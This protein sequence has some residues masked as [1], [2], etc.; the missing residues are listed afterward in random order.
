MNYQEFILNKSQIGRNYGFEPK[1]IPGMLFDF[2]RHLVEWSQR[3]GRAAIFADCGMGK[4]PM[5]LTWAYNVAEK[6]GKPVLL[7]T[8]LAVGKQMQHEGQK[9]QI[10]C[11]RS[12]NGNW[13]KD[14]RI[15]ITNYERLH[16]FNPH[17]FGG[18]VC[19]ESS[20]LK[21]YDGKTKAAIT[22][23]MRCLPYR[24]LGTATAAPND[25][26]ELGT[27]SEA[28]GEIGFMDMLGRFFKKCGSTTSRKD[29]LQA[30]KWRF[31]GHA[32]HD[33]WRWV[34]SWARAVRKPSDLGYDDGQFILPDLKINNHIIQAETMRDGFLLDLPAVSFF[35]QREETRRT[36]QER[37]EK[38]AY[39]VQNTGKPAVVW[40]HLNDE[41]NLLAKLIDGAVQVSGKDSDDFKVEAFE[42]FTDGNIRVLVTKPRIACFGLNWQHCNH[43]VYFPSHS[44]EQWYQSIRRFWRFGQS[45]PVT[46]DVVATEGQLVTM[47]NLQRKAKASDRTFSRITELMNDE[48]RL[49]IKNEYTNAEELPKWL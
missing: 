42:N 19:D 27:S 28:L 43:T 9:F 8:P 12:P 2:Q 6:T 23:F 32:E 34:C 30:D 36:L 26:I 25:Y 20:I 24:L 41:G 16:Y 45:Q 3:K 31:R 13:P 11:Y 48:L 7:A 22:E 18:M 1:F 4:S 14:Q 40:C 10:E 46:V 49:Q 47:Q 38:A 33:F 15:I 39:L 17:N 29:E 5:E 44:F 21:N 35:E 37:C